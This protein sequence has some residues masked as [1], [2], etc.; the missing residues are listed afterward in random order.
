[1]CEEIYENYG[2]LKSKL[3]V[4]GAGHAESYYKEREMYEEALNAFYR[5]NY[6]M[7]RKR[8]DIRYIR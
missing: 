3:I 4:P 1:M 6:K 7:M 5:R 8:K 2:A